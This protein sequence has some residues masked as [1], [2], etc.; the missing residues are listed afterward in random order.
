LRVEELYDGFMQGFTGCDQ[1]FDAPP[2]VAELLRR[3]EKGIELLATTRNTS[4][5]QPGPE[6]DA[7]LAEL[8]AV[9]PEVDRAVHVDLNAIAVAV[10]NWRKEQLGSLRGQ[11]TPR[12]SLH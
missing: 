5:R 8:K 11:T 7:M 12:G 2:G 4:A 10:K 9:F 3:V 6:D 1:Q